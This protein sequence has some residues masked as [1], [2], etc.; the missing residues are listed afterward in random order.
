MPIP[1]LNVL[2]ISRS[3]TFPCACNQVNKGGIVQLPF[4][5]AAVKP[6]G[7]TRGMF[8]VIPPPVICAMPFTGKA[9]MSSSKG[10]T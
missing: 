1:Q 2:Y 7:N 5:I 9:A 10:L 8:S 3:A 6:A 4:L